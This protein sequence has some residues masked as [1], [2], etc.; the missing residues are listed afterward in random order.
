MKI[1][2]QTLLNKD[3]SYDICWIPCKKKTYLLSFRLSRHWLLLFMKKPEHFWHYLKGL[4]DTDADDVKK[5]MAI[6]K[7]QT[8][9]QSPFLPFKIFD[10]IRVLVCN[11]DIADMLTC[12][13]W[14]WHWYCHLHW[15]WYWKWP[16]TPETDRIKR[17][18]HRRV[19]VYLI[20]DN[21]K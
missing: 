21:V 15:H 9:T 20:M 3:Y 5:P 17:H 6:S 8:R 19:D 16:Y 14:N 1:E 12:W 13:H 4:K 2:C 10:V 18:W 7:L 11:F